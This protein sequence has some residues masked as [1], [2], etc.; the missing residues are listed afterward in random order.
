MSL[1]DSFII[2]MIV[3][4]MSLVANVI[5]T[6]NGV[7]ESI[8]GLLMLI[9]MALAG[10][11]MAKF[12]PGNI[13]SVAYVVT[14]ACLLSYPGMPG[15]EYVNEYVK[16]VGFLQLCTPILAYAGVAIGKDLDAFAKSGWR[17]AIISC[18][19]FIGTYIGSALIAQAILEYMGQI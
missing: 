10:M 19:V 16:K 18:V 15:S 14:L 6:P 1:K 13:P 2:L 4:L 3:G 11:A 17:I 12:L 7:V 5:G 8:P 9:A